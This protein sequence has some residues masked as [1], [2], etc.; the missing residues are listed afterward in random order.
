MEPFICFRKSEQKIFF[1][2]AKETTMNFQYFFYCC[3]NCNITFKLPVISSY[4]EFLMRSE[5]GNLAHLYAINNK[6]FAEV[7]KIFHQNLFIINRKTKDF[8]QAK[9]FNREYDSKEDIEKGGIFQKIFSVACD[10]APDN[11]PYEISRKPLC[12]NCKKSNISSYGPLAEYVELDVKPVTHNAWN[13]LSQAE[14]ESLV[15]QAIK[16]II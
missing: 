3:K 1:S 9:K 2:S 14:K 16:K 8:E 7:S 4:G 11:T 10:L 13:K 5:T 15:D 12:P 6:V